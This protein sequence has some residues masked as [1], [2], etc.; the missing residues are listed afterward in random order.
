MHG[1]LEALSEAK[2]DGDVGFRLSEEVDVD[3]RRQRE[4]VGQVELIRGTNAHEEVPVLLLGAFLLGDLEPRTR[5]Q[6]EAIPHTKGH[7]GR[8]E[9]RPLVISERGVDQ[10]L[11]TPARIE[12]SLI[13]EADGGRHVIAR[14][15]PHPADEQRRMVLVKLVPTAVSFVVP[16]RLEHDCTNVRDPLIANTEAVCAPQR[17]WDDFVAC[18][19]VGGVRSR[20]GTSCQHRQERKHGES[21]EMAHLSLLPM[22]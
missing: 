12:A 20:R 11:D 5:H 22:Q 14:D 9:Q 17:G 3:G 4:S 13:G 18:R 16:G 2:V 6:L 19:G 21:C 1:E 15:R 10:R 7:T 8:D